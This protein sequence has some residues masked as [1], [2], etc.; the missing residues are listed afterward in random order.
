MSQLLVGRT[1]FLKGWRKEYI[2]VIAMVTA[3]TP[4]T[5]TIEREGHPPPPNL[6]V[7]TAPYLIENNRL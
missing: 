7:V 5:K 3:C 1:M 6:N 2:I 4:S